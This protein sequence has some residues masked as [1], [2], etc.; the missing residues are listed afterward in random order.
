MLPG[1]L[2]QTAAVDIGV[3]YRSGERAMEVGG[4]WYDAFWLK[5]GKRM[6]LVVGD[7]VGRGLDAA[8]AMGQMR[9]ATRALAFAAPGPA[10]LLE[11]LDRLAGLHG[12]GRWSTVVCAELQV[13]EG[14]LT[15]G[16]AGHPPPIVIRPGGEP[17]IAW[18]G[19]SVPLDAHVG[20]APRRDQATISLERG[21]RVVLYTDGLVE[22]PGSSID[23]GIDWLARAASERSAEGLAGARRVAARFSP[24]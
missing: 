21:T 18:G 1:A 13:E 6:L 20:G 10:R 3:A 14:S 9:S 2:P 22:R 11:D 23:K 17:E 8:A 16:C 5:A 24:G 7:V 4:D 19:R 15:Y 12:F